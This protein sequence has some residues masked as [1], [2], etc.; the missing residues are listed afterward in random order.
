MDEKGHPF[1]FMVD[2]KKIELLALKEW[3]E[4]GIKW[5]DAIQSSSLLS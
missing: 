2:Q 1:I 5:R 3:S 4:L